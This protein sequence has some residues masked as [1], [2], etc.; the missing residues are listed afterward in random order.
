MFV[1]GREQPVQ[2]R[3]RDQSKYGMKGPGVSWGWAGG[4][5]ADPARLCRQLS[6]LLCRPTEN[7]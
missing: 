2:R 7:N 4:R 3:G 5:Q 1:T 6:V